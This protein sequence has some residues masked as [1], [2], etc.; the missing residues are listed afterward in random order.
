MNLWQYRELINFAKSCAKLQKQAI[1]VH[2]QLPPK[3]LLFTHQN[4]VIEEEA[5]GELINGLIGDSAKQLWLERAEELGVRRID[6]VWKKIENS[7]LQ[8]P[9]LEQQSEYVVDDVQYEHIERQQKSIRYVEASIAK[10]LEK[11]VGGTALEHFLDWV[12]ILHILNELKVSRNEQQV[13]F[14]MVYSVIWDWVADL[15]NIRKEYCLA[16]F[17]ATVCAP[18]AYECGINDMGNVL[19]GITRGKYK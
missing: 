13:A 14:T 19:S 12:S 4:S 15:W 10:K 2:S 16:H 18:L 9:G 6:E 7:V 17:I 1:Q 8:C 5:R 3:E 11:K